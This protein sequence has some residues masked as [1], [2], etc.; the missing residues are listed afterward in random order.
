MFAPQQCVEA[1]LNHC[2]EPN[3]NIR[4]ESL[5]VA[6]HFGPLWTLRASSH[7]GWLKALGFPWKREPEEKTVA[8]V[9]DSVI[10]VLP[11]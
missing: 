9:R 11:S 2:S 6:V 8:H 1:R 7:G 4:C 10:P 3:I 5:T